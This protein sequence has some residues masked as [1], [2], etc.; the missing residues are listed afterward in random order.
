MKIGKWS[1]S[2]CA[3]MALA[4][5][6]CVADK[7]EEIVIDKAALQADLEVVSQARM[8]FGHQSVGRDLLAGLQELAVD[9]GV[10]L[11]VEEIDGLPSDEGPGLFHSNIGENGDP[12]SK[13]EVFASLLTRRERPAYD[14]AM[15]KFCYVDL[16]RETTIEAAALLDRYARL[17]DQLREQRPDVGIMHISLPLRADPPGKKTFVKRLLGRPTEEDADNVLRNAFNDGLRKRFAGEAF[18]DL[19][20]VESTLPDG[21]R[22]SFSR[23]GRTIHTL[24]QE[25]TTAGT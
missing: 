5:S 6:G 22:S 11:R 21:T 7:R 17:V 3:A 19:A 24:T 10:A 9:A 13:C 23:D 15:M 18:F 20:A 12:D 25:Y 8:L 2:A 1:L 16:G 14:M 4:V